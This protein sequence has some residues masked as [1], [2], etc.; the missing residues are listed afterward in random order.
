MTEPELAKN[1]LHL[2][3]RTRDLS[4]EVDWLRALGAVLLT[5]TPLVEDGW[6]WHVL[7]DPEGNELCLLQPPDA[8]WQDRG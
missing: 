3:L 4:A 5:T 6:T 7:A 1:R 8:H 2:D